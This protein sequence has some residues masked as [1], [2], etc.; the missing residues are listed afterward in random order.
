MRFSDPG[1]EEAQDVRHHAP[2]ARMTRVQDHRGHVGGVAV[3]LL[4]R[5]LLELE[6]ADEAERRQPVAG[7][8]A[9]VPVRGEE[10]LEPGGA[11]SS[12]PGG[13]PRL[14]I[15]W[16]WTS[17]SGSAARAQ[18]VRDEAGTSSRP[19]DRA[20]RILSSLSAWPAK[21]TTSP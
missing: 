15:A 9:D 2:P 17:H 7:V 12:S 8:V 1:V 4:A 6:H 10:G 13:C 20:A 14:R 21:R 18:S 19:R 16:A 11:R 5:D 3:L